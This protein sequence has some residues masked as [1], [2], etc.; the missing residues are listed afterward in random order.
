MSEAA[1][2]R[3][4]SF[5]VR[6]FL[7]G[8]SRTKGSLT[9]I[10]VRARGGKVKFVQQD[11]EQSKTWKNSMVR[12]LREALGITVARVAG[13]KVER[14]DGGQPYGGAVEVH[15]FFRFDRQASKAAAAEA[16]EIWPSHQD[17]WPVA[18]DIGDVDKL[19]RNLLDALTQ[20]GVLADDRLVVAG[21]ELKRWCREGERPG[22]DILVRP[23]GAWAA[24]AERIMLRPEDA[25]DRVVAIMDDWHGGHA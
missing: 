14:T 20:A 7:A 19:T 12:Q 24:Y 18:L 1:E 2:S 13:G 16:G 10:P 11:T 21:A 6:L 4:E 8:R 17:E 22:V 9:G 25:T 3:T 15:R 5:E 23:A